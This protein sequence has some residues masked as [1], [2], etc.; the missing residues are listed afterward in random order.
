MSCSVR[1]FVPL[2]SIQDP[3]GFN[4]QTHTENYSSSGHT[5]P[6]CDCIDLRCY[7]SVLLTYLVTYLHSICHYDVCRVAQHMTYTRG[8]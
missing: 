6:P 5:A 8:D 3:A 2:D 1:G 7:T 4:R